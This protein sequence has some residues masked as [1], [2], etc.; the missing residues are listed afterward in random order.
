MNLRE[1][2][3]KIQ[4]EI[5]IF[6]PNSD[7]GNSDISFVERQLREVRREALEEAEAALSVLD[8]SR[9]MGTGATLSNGIRAIRALA[10]KEGKG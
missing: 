8:Q 2:A 4:S 7:P 10:E 3:E 1:R 6:S 5:G 9:S